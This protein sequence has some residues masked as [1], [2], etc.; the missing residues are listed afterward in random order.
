M[1]TQTVCCG[2]CGRPYERPDY[3]LDLKKGDQVIYKSWV[4]TGVA[5]F[6]ITITDTKHKKDGLYFG[7]E[8]D[9]VWPNQIHEFVRV[10]TKDDE[11]INCKDLCVACKGRAIVYE[12]EDYRKILCGPC[13]FNRKNGGVCR[14]SVFDQERCGVGNCPTCKGICYTDG[15]IFKREGNWPSEGR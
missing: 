1:K 6:P 8:R 5:N 4:G 13:K 12:E 11:Y 3:S 7:W 2:E 10:D 14:T 15:R 9:V